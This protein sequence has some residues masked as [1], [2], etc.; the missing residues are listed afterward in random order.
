MLSSTTAIYFCVQ[1]ITSLSAL[2][3]HQSSLNFTASHCCKFLIVIISHH[4]NKTLQHTSKENGTG[5]KK[6]KKLQQQ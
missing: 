4:R 5:K 6:D 1:E 2:L 3:T